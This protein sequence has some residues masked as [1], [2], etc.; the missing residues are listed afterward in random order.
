VHQ[1]DANLVAEAV[2]SVTFPDVTARLVRA[3]ES[4]VAPRNERL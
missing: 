1:S 4:R 2:R 3:Q